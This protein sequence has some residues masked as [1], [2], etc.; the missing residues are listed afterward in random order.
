MNGLIEEARDSQ[1]GKTLGV[2]VSGKWYTTKNWQFRD[3][4]GQ[5]ISFTPESSSY[6]GKTILWINDYREG[7]PTA[8][9]AMRNAMSQPPTTPVGGEATTVTTNKMVVDRDGSIV[10]QA[11]TK[12]C[13]G[14]GD[15]ADLVW[16]RYQTFYRKYQAW[17]TGDFDDDIPF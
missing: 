7:S 16:N 14:P 1:S 8:D 5:S 6:N 2:K 15:D 9:D 4:I 10:A 3:M 13:T 11:L 17:V 12:A